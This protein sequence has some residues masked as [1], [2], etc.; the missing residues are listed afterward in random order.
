MESFKQYDETASTIVKRCLKCKC[1]FYTIKE[2]NLCLDCE[3][4]EAINEDN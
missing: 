2:T 4:K 3:E 1:T